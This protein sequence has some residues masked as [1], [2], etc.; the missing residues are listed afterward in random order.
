MGNALQGK[1]ALVTGASRGI[2]EAI[3]R[4]FAAEGA[5]VVITARTVEA[6]SGRHHGGTVG[7]GDRDIALPG[8]DRKSTRLNSSHITPSRMPSSA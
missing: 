7:V 1:I 6:G 8:S 4:R 5:R 2:G 3:A